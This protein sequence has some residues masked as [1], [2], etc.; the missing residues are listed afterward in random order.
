MLK[1][2]KYWLLTGLVTTTVVLSAMEARGS[3]VFQD[4]SKSLG[5]ADELQQ[6]LDATSTCNVV[7]ATPSPL[8]E[9]ESTSKRGP[10]GKDKPEVLVNSLGNSPLGMAPSNASL[11][12]VT[13]SAGGGSAITS[14][15]EA[16]LQD[17]LQATLSP[18]SR[19]D[20]PRGPTFRW[21]RPPR[22]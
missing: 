17:S 19:L 10:Q 5:A 15:L 14:Q 7:D 4:P 6:W 3:F 20:L 11:S 12:Q 21:F 13:G 1:A 9:V 18:E 22:V 8:F 16:P 2:L